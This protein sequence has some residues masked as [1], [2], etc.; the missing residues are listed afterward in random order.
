MPRFQPARRALSAKL[1]GFTML[2]VLLTLVII[3]VALLGTAGLHSFAMKMN[4]GGQLRTQAVI[5]GLDLLE[6]IEANNESAVAGNYAVS[7]LP[8]SATVDCAAQPCTPADL[9]TYDLNQFRQRLLAQLPNSSVTI[10]R[11]G[12]GPFI[13]TVQVNWQERIAKAAGSATNP[14]TGSTVAASGQTETFSYT[15]SKTIYDKELV[16]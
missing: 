9:A 13:Y 14:G 16:I 1:R 8:T 2:E 5:L 15:V 4:Q 10:T 6:R 7:T 12:A 11:T 3:A